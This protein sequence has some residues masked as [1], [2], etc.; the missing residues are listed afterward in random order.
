VGD[1]L[2]AKKKNSNGVVIAT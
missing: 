1:V 2:N